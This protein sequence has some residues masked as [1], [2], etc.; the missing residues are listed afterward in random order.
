M[1]Q[2]HGIRR[3]V[4][5]VAVVVGLAFTGALASGPSALA[6]DP[7]D[8][9][10]GYAGP[11]SGCPGTLTYVVYL[12]N[13][14]GTSLGSALHVWYSSAS[15]GTYCAMTFDNLASS[16]HMEVVVRRGDWQ[17]WWYDSGTYNTYA[18]AIAVYGAASKC[19]YFF[20]RVTVSGVNYE[21]RLKT[22]LCP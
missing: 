16:H 3:K 2:L 4:A 15:G 9:P 13:A 20:G 11:L 5:A 18:G 19:V 14:A 1:Y 12:R 22:L 17:T 6:T 10:P 7:D 8:A 21:V